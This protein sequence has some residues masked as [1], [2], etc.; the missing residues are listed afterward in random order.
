MLHVQNYAINELNFV[1]QVAVPPHFPPG[2]ASGFLLQ[3]LHLH[4]A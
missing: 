1:Q 4:K 2:R 3:S